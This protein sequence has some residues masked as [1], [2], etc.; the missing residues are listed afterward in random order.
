MSKD[1]FFDSQETVSG[2]EPSYTVPK[3]SHWL[4]TPNSFTQESSE[5]I[6]D[7]IRE[8]IPKHNRETPAT[9]EILGTVVGHGS[10]FINKKISSLDELI[11]Y[12]DEL[13]NRPWYKFVTKNY[14]FTTA[15]FGN[16]CLY[17]VAAEDILS[18][19]NQTLNI[20]YAVNEV[21]SEGYFKDDRID[22]MKGVS[23]ASDVYSSYPVN[24]NST[25]GKETMDL[26]KNAN[27]KNPD[28]F[29]NKL[30]AIP[31]V[32]RISYLPSIWTL[33][34]E[35]SG[36][37][38]ISFANTLEAGNRNSQADDDKLSGL[39]I[40]IL[41]GVNSKGEQKI[42][43]F[44]YFFNLAEEVCIRNIFDYFIPA[45]ELYDVSNKKIDGSELVDAFRNF[46]N[47]WNMN[48]PSS[49]DYDLTVQ[50][51]TDDNFQDITPF[52][53]TKTN[54]ITAYVFSNLV[55]DF[56]LIKTLDPSTPYN[57][58]FPEWTD[59][60]ESVNSKVFWISTVCE[61]VNP[62]YIG[63][64][65]LPSISEYFTEKGVEA[66]STQKEFALSD[67]G[68]GGLKKTTVVPIEIEPDL[69]TIL[70][71]NT[72]IAQDYIDAQDKIVSN[73]NSP[74]NSQQTDSYP[75]SPLL[76]E[77]KRTK[78]EES[79]ADTKKMKKSGGTKKYGKNKKKN[80]KKLRKNKKNTKKRLK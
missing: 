78:P 66:T 74:T 42:F 10:K 35:N 76:I 9:R 17:N 48:I 62:K 28:W 37:Q 34:G 60:L 59:N 58:Q 70:L 20:N 67:A 49:G 19:I 43:H 55:L 75:D 21:L 15:V 71:T 27:K 39:F 3:S 22:F 33:S 51:K 26:F 80:T 40:H 16:P 45:I 77:K 32:P 36:P 23:R 8:N 54:N 4:F 18:T 65:L 69:K 13:K 79:V 29:I 46:I 7:T 73:I 11:K 52:I 61:V 2:E 44:P 72:T 38:F 64:D 12:L 5:E 14:F 41:K 31:N 24:S 30:V 63:D 1:V 56:L 53:I 25:L 57:P 50:F 6:L 47:I 68:G